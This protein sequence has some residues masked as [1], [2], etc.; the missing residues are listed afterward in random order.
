MIYFHFFKR[1]IH[2]KKKTFKKDIVRKHN[3]VLRVITFFNA[4]I[5]E[6]SEENMLQTDLKPKFSKMCREHLNIAF[7][8]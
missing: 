4:N 7:S 1:R 6:D 8:I 2:S 3:T 5:N